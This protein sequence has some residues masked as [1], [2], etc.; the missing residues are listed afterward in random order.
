MGIYNTAGKV[1]EVTGN[2]YLKNKFGEDATY[3]VGCQVYDGQ[4]KKD[5]HG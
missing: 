5:A 3:V 4:N 1:L 2:G